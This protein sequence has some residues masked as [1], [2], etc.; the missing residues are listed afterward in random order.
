VDA[1][2]WPFP[3]RTS[4]HR[5]RDLRARGVGSG[6]LGRSLSAFVL[7]SRS[8]CCCTRDVAAACFLRPYRRCGNLGRL[9]GRVGSRFRVRM[10]NLQPTP[11]SWSDSWTRRSATSRQPSSR[12]RRARLERGPC[13][14]TSGHFLVRLEERGRSE[15]T[16]GHLLVGLLLVPE[17]RG[18]SERTSGHLLVRLLLV[19]EERGHSERTSGHLLVGLLEAPDSPRRGGSRRTVSARPSFTRRCTL[20]PTLTELS[21]MDTRARS[22]RQPPARH[23]RIGT[24]RG[25]EERET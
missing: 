16:S 22:T 13:K 14:R 15:R 25:G 8:S 6:S 20:T 23:T 4:G 10:A 17:D 18:R 21:R 9:L 19:P 3:A 2:T 24:F 12:R 11:E 7:K 5:E 1:S